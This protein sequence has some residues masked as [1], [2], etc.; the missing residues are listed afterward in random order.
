MPLPNSDKD[1]YTIDEMMGR[2]K[3]RKEAE[4]SPELVTRSDGSQALRVKKRKRRT[5]QSV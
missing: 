3:K 2:L 4:M 1:K 5:D